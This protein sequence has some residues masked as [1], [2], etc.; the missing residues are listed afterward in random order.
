[1]FDN[2]FLLSWFIC[3]LLYTSASPLVSRALDIAGEGGD[4]ALYTVL[5]PSLQRAIYDPDAP[6]ATPEEIAQRNLRSD[7]CP[8][9]QIVRRT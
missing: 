6:N 8:V 4:E 1:M 9:C 2:I 3:C 5:T 7:V